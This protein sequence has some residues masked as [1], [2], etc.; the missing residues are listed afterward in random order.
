MIVCNTVDWQ[1][2]EQTWIP[3]CLGAGKSG[4]RMLAGWVRG[5]GRPSCLAAGTFSLRPHCGQS[6][7]SG[8]SSHRD[9]EPTKDPVSAKLLHLWLLG[10]LP[11]SRHV[12]LGFGPQLVW[13]GRPRVSVNL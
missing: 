6:E 4:V 1:L 11:R 9:A 8:V 7:L 12:G 2:R 10:H 13:V 3:H 5:P